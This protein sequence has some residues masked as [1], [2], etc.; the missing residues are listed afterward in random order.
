MKLRSIIV[1]L[2]AGVLA[3]VLGSCRGCGDTGRVL[4]LGLDGLD[5]QVIDLLLSEGELPHFAELRGQGAYAPLRSMRPLLSP[6]IWTTVATGKTPDQHG[7]G[8]FVARAASGDE[9]PVTS[10]L[11]QVEALW[12]IASAADRSVATVGWWAT[13]PPEAVNGYVVSDHVGYH[14]LFEE[15]LASRLDEGSEAVTYPPELLDRFTPMLR[16]PWDLGFEELANYVDVSPSEL[17]EELDFGQD[18]DHFRWALATAQNYRDIGLALW[19]EEQ[20]DLELVYIEGVDSSSHLFGHLFRAEGLQGELEEQRLRYGRAVEQM[21]HF[22]DELLG[23]Y[24]EN[25]DE[26]TTLVVLSDH[27]FRLGDLHDDPSR[28]RDL[29]RVSERFHREH[30]ILYLYGN[31]VRPGVRLKDPSIL[32]IAPT[33]LSLLGLPAGR[34]MPGR[35]L[36]EGLVRPSVPERLASW[37]D[38]VPP[39]GQGIGKGRG[40]TIGQAQ[41]DHLRSPGLPWQGLRGFGDHLSE[42]REQFG[43]DSV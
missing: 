10:D 40:D 1:V 26:D 25:L 37:E 16:K 4:V 24:L 14:F 21:Y 11:R 28:A 29:R 17:T 39:E 31:K 35:V 30:G 34:D 8:H 6:I 13:W 42:R 9:L 15:G 36:E 19:R 3:L 23:E 43:G 2:F 22:A 7:I 12:T 41:L 33:V 32:D 38:E 20:P 5:P 18:L 27:G